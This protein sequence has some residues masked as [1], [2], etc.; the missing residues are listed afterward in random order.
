[1]RTSARFMT[2]GAGLVLGAG[3]RAPLHAQAFIVG[4]V[5]DSAGRGLGGAQVMLEGTTTEAR[6]DSIGTFRLLASPATYSLLVRH[7]GYRA[8]RRAVTAATN[9]TA[10]V[11]ITLAASERPE[12]D[13]IT[14]R[15]DLDYAPGRAGFAYRRRVG[16]GTFID[17]TEMRKND[18]RELSSILRRIRGLRIVPGPPRTNGGS[19]VEWAAHPVG[20]CYVA[21]M[22]D[23]VFI[24]RG[25]S[26]E[27]PPDLKR[28]I[29]STDIE[30]VE[31]YRGG[32]PMP[33]E[34]L[35]RSADCGVLVLW[36]RRGEMRRR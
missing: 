16:L 13:T 26:G 34:F 30:S 22:I 20:G 3:I 31:Y 24:Y 33:P 17:S 12:L 2:L 19:R 6:T 27:T 7:V 4:Q 23:N 5:R 1:M 28:E 8:I 36:T 10:R 11:L 18:G 14:V 29:L 32:G 25:M 15:A 9:D 35:I 21:V